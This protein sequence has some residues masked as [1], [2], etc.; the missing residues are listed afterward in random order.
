MVSRLSF[1]V[2]SLGLYQTE[3]PV[4]TGMLYVPGDASA[5]IV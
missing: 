2:T 4:L 5:Y 3:I 1:W